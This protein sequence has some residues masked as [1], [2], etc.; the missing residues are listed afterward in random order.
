MV[1]KGKSELP[2]LNGYVKDMQRKV[3]TLKLEISKL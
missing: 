1:S 3:Q 2:E